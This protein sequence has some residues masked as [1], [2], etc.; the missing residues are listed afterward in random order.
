MR[1]LKLER[2]LAVFDIESTGVLPLHDRIVELA[3]LKVMPDGTR[4]M[5]VRRLN[6]GIPIPPEAAAIHGITDDDV[7][8]CPSFADIAAK[9]YRYLDGCD[10]AGYNILSF[11]VPML[12]KEFERAGIEFKTDG[13]HIADAFNIFCKLYPRR[14]SDAYRIFTGRELEGAH[15][16]GADT[17]A[18]YQVL[19]G[20]IARHEE[21]P[22]TAEGLA[23]Y[24]NLLGEDGIDQT[25]RLRWRGGEVIINFG[26]NT[27]RTLRDLS[28]ND[29]GFLR[30]ILHG[31]FSDEVK[32]IVSDALEGKFPERKTQP[33]Q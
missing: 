28:V 11:D 26:K 6:P 27:G 19:L 30:W 21:V 25:R 7:K 3:I 5:N 18:A 2:P 24:S 12:R 31:D 15:G 16:A 29:P 23:A 10:L 22:D 14:L 33:K 13:R 17:E 1:E 4:Q 32:K 9:L 8:D 20:E